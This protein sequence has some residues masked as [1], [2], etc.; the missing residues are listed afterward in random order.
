V[1]PE[2]MKAYLEKPEAKL[3]EWDAMIVVWNAKKDAPRCEVR[4]KREAELD[5]VRAKH[6]GLRARLRELCCSS[7]NA[8]ETLAADFGRAE[9]T[10]DRRQEKPRGDLPGEAEERRLSCEHS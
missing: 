9:R 8:R 4:P 2:R 6:E 7:G 3:K 1:N 5:N 10:R